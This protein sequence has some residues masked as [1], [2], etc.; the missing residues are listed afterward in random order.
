MIYVAFSK[1]CPTENART[2]SQIIHFFRTT[3][4]PGKKTIKERDPEKRGTC[5]II[6]HQDTYGAEGGQWTKLHNAKCNN[7]DKTFLSFFHVDLPLVPIFSPTVFSLENCKNLN[8]LL[9]KTELAMLRH[10][11]PNPFWKW[12]MASQ[13]QH[14]IIFDPVKG[15]VFQ[16]TDNE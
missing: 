8:G 15:V 2:H 14:Q 13:S 11:Y 4:G 1:M 10:Y 9:L 16:A 7:Q 3:W 6:T 12:K 5:K